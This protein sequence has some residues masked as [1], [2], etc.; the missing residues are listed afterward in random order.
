MFMNINDYIS[1]IRQLYLAGRDPNQIMQTVIN[2]TPN[3]KQLNAQYNNLAQG[4]SRKDVILQ[5]AKQ[6]GV[7][8]EN[9]NW[10]AQMLGAK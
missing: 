7:N 9:L 6:Q 1:N 4:R 2:N 8:E 10:L 5:M 3:I